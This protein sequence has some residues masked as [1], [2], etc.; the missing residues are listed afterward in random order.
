[1]DSLPESALFNSRGF[2]TQDDELL[3]LFILLYIKTID[4]RLFEI[5]RIWKPDCDILS[6]NYSYQFMSG[7]C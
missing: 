6:T 3:T 7:P 4:L 5:Q 1:M 2:P